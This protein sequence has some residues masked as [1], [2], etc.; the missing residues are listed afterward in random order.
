MLSDYW[1]L[2]F[3]VA[4]TVGSIATAAALIFVGLQERLTRKQVYFMS[5]TR[6]SEQVKLVRELLDG[7]EMRVLRVDESI[8]KEP[9]SKDEKLLEVYG[10]VYYLLQQTEYFS[11]L[12]ESNEISDENILRFC[13]PLLHSAFIDLNIYIG[14]LQE[15][16][17]GQEYK[18]ALCKRLNDVKDP[19]EV[20]YL[21]KDVKY[22][23]SGPMPL[24]T[25]GTMYK[26]PCTG[27]S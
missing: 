6:R 21:D 20:K 12:I 14:R 2:V 19:I 15:L 7:I 1:A 26:D 5:E 13:V 17:L 3:G 27:N 9:A 23:Y 16:G 25:S 24:P 10:A 4:G 8:D 22:R 11:Y 18:D